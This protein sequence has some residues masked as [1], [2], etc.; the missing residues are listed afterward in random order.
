LS[1]DPEK[2]TETVFGWRLELARQG[3]DVDEHNFELHLVNELA[4]HNQV[5]ACALLSAVLEGYIQ[6]CRRIGSMNEARRIEIHNRDSS[7][8]LKACQSECREFWHQL[9]PVFGMVVILANELK[10][11]PE[12]LVSYDSR[13]S[14]ANLA[15]FMAELLQLSGAE[16]LKQEGSMFIQELEELIQPPASSYLRQ[17][18]VNILSAAPAGLADEAIDCFLQI[19]SP[20]DINTESDPTL[21]RHQDSLSPQDP[22]MNTFARLAE[23]CSN[24]HFNALEDLVLRFHASYEKKDVKTQLRRSG[25]GYGEGTSR[26]TMAYPNTLCSWPSRLSVFRIEES[27][28]CEHGAANLAIFRAIVI[29]D[30]TVCAP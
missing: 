26:T 5:R 1:I 27:L 29:L 2:D 22:A 4:N 19:E 12:G 10:A 8:L 16:R 18:I 14:T 28:H 23:Y 7:Y 9:I 21:L 24:D 25:T 11:G 3:L 20:L 6:Y 13:V 30:L 17:L 15:R